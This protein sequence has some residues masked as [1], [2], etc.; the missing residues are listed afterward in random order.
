MID[1]KRKRAIGENV[2]LVGDIQ[3]W[4]PAGFESWHFMAMIDDPQA[5]VG[6]IKTG[7]KWRAYYKQSDQYERYVTWAEEA[8]PYVEFDSLEEA[9]TWAEVAMRV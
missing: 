7:D 4:A 3:C 2:F 9:A 1:W 6:I 5:R 8:L